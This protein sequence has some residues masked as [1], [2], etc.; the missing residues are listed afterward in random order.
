MAF[1]L[2]KIL[3]F[4]SHLVQYSVT[5][6]GELV[7]GFQPVMFNIDRLSPSDVEDV[8]ADIW[9]V[10][11]I[12]PEVTIKDIKGM[13]GGPIYG[14][15]KSEN[16]QWFYHVVALQSWWRKESRTVFGCSVPIFAEAVRAVLMG[17][18]EDV[19]T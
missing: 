2:Y 14:F 19:S 5:S 3:G 18:S 15:R 16:G 13:S 1:S 17:E 4:P 9:F 6:S 12:P 10:G 11:C 7:G 8:P